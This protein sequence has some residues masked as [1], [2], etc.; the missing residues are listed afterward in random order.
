MGTQQLHLHA[1]DPAEQARRNT[2]ERRKSRA[3]AGELV[4]QKEP[5]DHVKDAMAAMAA[6]S[7]IPHPL[8]A[9]KPDQNLINGRDAVDSHALNGSCNSVKAERKDALRRKTIDA[10]DQR[11]SLLANTNINSGTGSRTPPVSAATFQGVEK[12][13]ARQRRKS[14]MNAQLPSQSGDND[15]APDIYDALL[16]LSK[17]I[18]DTKTNDKK[19]K[20]F[21]KLV[22]KHAGIKDYIDYALACTNLVECTFA[23]INPE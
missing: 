15:S 11:V 19:K 6:A 17:D 13:T 8:P 2:R 12:I 4:E 22:A 16:A 5:G 23:A 3:A 14:T 20:K 7:T 9:S 1:K 21:E 18:G 10:F